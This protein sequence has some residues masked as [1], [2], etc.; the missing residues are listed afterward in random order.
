[1]FSYYYIFS[2]FI[3]FVNLKRSA[4]FSSTKLLHFPKQILKCFHL[5]FGF[6]FSFCISISLS[7]TN[8]LLFVN[9]QI[10]PPPF[11]FFFFKFSH[12]IFPQ[13]P[14]QNILGLHFCTDFLLSSL[15]NKFLVLSSCPLAKH[16]ENCVFG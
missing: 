12:H 13:Q 3:C 6:F 5:P 2:Y 7:S 15:S 4:I 10:L 1:M 16:H 8:L 11:I 14:L 9:C